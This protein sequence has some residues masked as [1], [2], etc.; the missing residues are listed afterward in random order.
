MRFAPLAPI[1]SGIS[2][3]CRLPGAAISVLT[4]SMMTLLAAGSLG[5]QAVGRWEVGVSAGATLLIGSRTDFLDAGLG[6][7]L[8]LSFRLTPGL[9]LRADAIYARLDDQTDRA[10]EVGNHITL[11]SVGP[12]T[13]KGLGPVDVFL[14]GLV[15]AILNRQ[16][17]SNSLAGEVGTWAPVVGTGIGARVSVSRGLALVAGADLIKAGELDFARTAAS[18]YTATGDPF[19]LRAHGGIRI[20]IP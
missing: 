11:L 20:R 8:T 16:V 6:S 19:L 3:G 13:R 1:P 15:G 10:E 4:L 18:G 5:A 7:E 2:L 17:R 9:Q 14:R 12:E